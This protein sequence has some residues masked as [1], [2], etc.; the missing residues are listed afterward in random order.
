[1]PK[2]R[3]D[4]PRQNE[5]LIEE[6]KKELRDFDWDTNSDDWKVTYRARYAAGYRTIILNPKEDCSKKNP[7][8]TNKSWFER[9]YVIEGFSE[10]KMARICGVEKTTIGNWRKKHNIPKTIPRAVNPTR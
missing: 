7:L 4:E 10:R 2:V 9:L 3:K 8:Y 1:M 6:I 5:R